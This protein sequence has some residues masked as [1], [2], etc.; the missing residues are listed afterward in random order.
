MSSTDTSGNSVSVLITTST[1]ALQLWEYRSAVS[2]SQG[3]VV[4]QLWTREE[5]LTDIR[6]ATFIELPERLTTAGGGVGE[7]EEGFVERVMRQM[8]DARSFPTYLVHFI[9]RFVT[10]SYDSVSASIPGVVEDSTI[11]ANVSA[12]YRDSFGIRKVIVAATTR[13]I[14]FGLDSSNGAILWRRLLG[15]GWAH[16]VGG[17]HVPV[18]MFVVKTV[19]D[20][21]RPQVVFVTQRLANNVRADSSL[22]K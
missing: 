10:G 15:L 16:E 13:G 4:K 22:M 20:G 19:Q 5:S 8:A 12:L 21:E 2:D 14:V 9:K 1:G 11:A 7:A 3:P 6:V 17:R 18:K